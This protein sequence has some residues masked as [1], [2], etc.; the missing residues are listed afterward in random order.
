MHILVAEDDAILADALYRAL[1][2]SAFA[3]DLVTNGIHADSALLLHTYDLVVLDIGLPGMS[4]FGVLQN[5]RPRKSCVPVL[6]LT[7]SDSL[8]DRVRGL[9]LGADDYLG[10]P[11]DLPE[12]EARVQAL[13]RR[14]HGNPAPDLQHGSLRL[15]CAWPADC[16]IRTQTGPL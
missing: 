13:L 2:Q 16:I 14:G 9:D 1:A 4:E 5:L 11:F 12:L 8:A 6:L 3:V 7:A 10:K 15:D